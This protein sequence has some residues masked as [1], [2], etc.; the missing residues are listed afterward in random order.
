MTGMG[1]QEAGEGRM[2]NHFGH[3]IHLELYVHVYEMSQHVLAAQLL[4]NKE[5]KPVQIVCISE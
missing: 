2:R 3:Q 5:K 1:S 4:L